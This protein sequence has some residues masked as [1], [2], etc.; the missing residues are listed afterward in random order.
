MGEVAVEVL[1][2]VTLRIH[3]RQVLAILGPSGSGKS[4]LLRCLNGLIPRSYSG[5]L[6]GTIA[7]NG[8]DPAG[9]GRHMSGA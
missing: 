7:I 6:S 5:D 2:D 3:D 8:H 4:T 1:R 9:L